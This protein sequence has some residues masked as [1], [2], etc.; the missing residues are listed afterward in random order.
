[1]VKV[2]QSVAIFAEDPHRGEAG[3]DD[4]PC[5]FAEPPDQP[6]RLTLAGQIQAQLD[7]EGQARGVALLVGQTLVQRLG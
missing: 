5:P 7:D 1:M 6:G 2:R 3:R 4:V